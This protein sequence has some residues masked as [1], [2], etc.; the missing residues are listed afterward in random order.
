[1][2]AQDA[3]A[4]P[5]AVR[6][7]SA[8]LVSADIQ[9]AREQ[10]RSVVRTWGMRYTLHLLATEDIGWL[11]PL[12][13]PVF[14]RASQRR[15]ATLGLDENTCVRAIRLLRDFLASQGPATRAQIVEEIAKHGIRLEGQ[16]APH[17]IGRAAL[18][19]LVCLGPDHD[20]KPTYVLLD[21]WVD[22][23]KP[24][25]RE[26]ALAELARR[27]LAAYGPAGLEDLAAWS[28]LPMVDVRTGIQGI[29][30]ELLVVKVA[31]RPTWLPEARATWLHE[32]P[33]H[34]PVVRLLPS[35]DNYLLGYRSRDLVVPP[36]HAKRVHPGGGV[37]RPTLLV[38]GFV[39]GTWRSKRRRGGLSI[40]VE[41]FDTIVAE[42]QAGLQEEVADLGR[43]L[44]VQ[45]VLEL[46]S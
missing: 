40:E 25:P 8:N 7:R 43:F 26:A 42:V 44:G 29:A 35:F 33:P 13:G 24:L 4:A 28:G 14:V 10:D 37:I 30:S 18:E 45:A 46:T 31:G 27:Y 19:A 39:V 38:N 6:A 2:Q 3:A 1:V 15:R 12:L 16:A 41:A 20:G 34:D 22:R 9:R 11:L 23:G 5:L 21:D 32:P 17:L 36:E